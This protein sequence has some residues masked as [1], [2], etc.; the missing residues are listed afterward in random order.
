M[1]VVV[2][3]V[4][5]PFLAEALAGSCEVRALPTGEI[6]RSALLDADAVVV[7][8]ETRV[9][10]ALLEGTRVR[11]VGTATIGTDHVDLPYLGNRGIGFASA[12]GSNANSVAEYFATAL[13]VLAGRLGIELRGLT[14]G[15]VGVGNVGSRV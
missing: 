15:I 12:P 8:S 5:N 9:D 14:L 3:D 4:K 11:F 13:L 6:T 2:V 10:A 7:R 1:T